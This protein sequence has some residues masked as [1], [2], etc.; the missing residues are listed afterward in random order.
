MPS[1]LRKKLRASMEMSVLPSVSTWKLILC[2][3]PSTSAESAYW[4]TESPLT[5]CTMLPSFAVIESYE[6]ASTVMNSVVVSICAMTPL[7]TFWPSTSTPATEKIH[8]VVG[9]TVLRDDA[10]S[11]LTVLKPLSV[12]NFWGSPKMA[13]FTF[14]HR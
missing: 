4:F 9:D 8:A 14:S 3:R 7:A 1:T 10:S 11:V 6:S 12:K 13:R 2:L 5:D